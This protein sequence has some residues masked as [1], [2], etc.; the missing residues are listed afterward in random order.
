MAAVTLGAVDRELQHVEHTGIA[1]VELE[2]DHLRV[3]IDPEN[4]LGEVVGADREAIEQF[5]E[6][7]DQ[8][9]VVRDLAHHVNLKAVLA[10]LKAVSRHD[11]EHFLG[12]VDASA[13]WNHQLQVLQP[14]DVPHPA[15]G[16]AFEREA[17]AHRRDARS[18]QHL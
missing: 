11:V 9:D 12:L 14:H 1:F 17:R 16:L 8:D 2:G 6:L 7:V 3:A 10:A 15:H 13:E 4:Q 18:G 5:G